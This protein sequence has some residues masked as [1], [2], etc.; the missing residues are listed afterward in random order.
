MKTFDIPAGSRLKIL[1]TTPHKEHHGKDLKQA[2]SLR[3][4][5]WPAD[6]AALNMLADGLQD[7]LFHIP[8]EVMKQN[9]LDGIPDVKKWRRC[10]DL[11]MPVKV[12][13]L[14]FS[15]YTLGIEHG[16]DDTTTLALY[17][18]VLSK[19]EAET[20]EGGG[21]PIRF[22]LNS[23]REI[24]PELIGALCALEGSD[25]TITE[26]TPPAAD[27][28]DGSTEAF[29]ADHP[30]AGQLFADAHGDAADEIAELEGEER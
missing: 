3:L 14:E 16:V 4:E 28:I 22:S 24:T 26:L 29:E 6:N 20:K 17:S 19:F 12:P 5:W 7:S 21:A 10:P 27:A 2:V 18:C 30:D 23:S 25:V 8:P 11:A 13:K 1:K 9:A 15:G